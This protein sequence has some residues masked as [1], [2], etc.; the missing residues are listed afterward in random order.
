MLLCKHHGRNER[1]AGAG[2][3]RPL[4]VDHRLLI[5]IENQT[6]LRAIDTK[7]MNRG[8]H[9][10]GESEVSR[11]ARLFGDD[12]SHLVDDLAFAQA[13]KKRTGEPMRN[14]PR[15]IAGQKLRDPGDAVTYDI[16]Q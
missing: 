7:L 1:L 16:L 11:G 14:Y 10:R 5:L 6:V 15:R 12:D 2:V 3:P 4:K 13:L 8:T 9:L